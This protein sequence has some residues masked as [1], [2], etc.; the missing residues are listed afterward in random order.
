MFGTKSSSPGGFM[1]HLARLFKKTAQST[2]AAILASFFLMTILPSVSALAENPPFRP[3]PGP[4]PS[5]IH[6]QPDFQVSPICAQTCNNSSLFV[7]FSTK[8]S[9]SGNVECPTH[10]QLTTSCGAYACESNKKNCLA[11]CNSIS[12]CA[13]GFICNPQNHT[14]LIMTYSCS[15][16][17]H[18]VLA[19]D[20]AIFDCNGFRCSAG[21]C[22]TTCK[23]T[24]DCIDGMNCKTDTG[25]CVY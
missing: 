12:D 18:S 24:D 14:C 4:I 21:Q 11:T 9:Q 13:P 20:G 1:Y 17:Q 15:P 22:R 19:S 6:P 2:F 10:P 7:T 8:G 5:P 23:V 3:I 25:Q 16:D